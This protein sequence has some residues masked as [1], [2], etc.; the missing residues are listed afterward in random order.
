MVIAERNGI[1]IEVNGNEILLHN[2]SEGM[3]MSE[4]QHLSIEL[5]PNQI[6]ALIRELKK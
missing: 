6:E 4:Y 3:N 1:T 5:K 2:N